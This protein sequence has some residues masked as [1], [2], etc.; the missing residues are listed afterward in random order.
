MR[1]REN[2]TPERELSRTL[3]ASLM[4]VAVVLILTLVSVPSAWAASK[5]KTLYKFT[6]GADGGRSSA[7]LI[8]DQ[9]GN[10]YGT[11]YQG[12][13]SGFGTVFKLAPSGHGGWKQ[14]VLH[15]FGEPQ[16]GIHPYA[17]LIFDI[18]GNLYGTTEDGGD[19]G[20]GTVFKLTPNGDGSWTESV[21]YSFNHN[22]DGKDGFGPLAGLVL[23][24]AGSLYGTTYWGGGT[25]G[26][27]VVFELTPNGDGS[28]TESVLHTFTN[29]RK[30]AHQ[31][32]LYPY[33]GLVFDL[34]GNLYGATERGGSYG[35]GTVFRLVANGDGSWTESLIHSF[36]GY[37]GVGPEGSLIFDQQGN[38]YGTVGGGGNHERGAVFELIPNDDGSWIESILHSFTFNDGYEPFAGLTFDQSGNLYGTTDGGGAYGWGTVFQLKPVKGGWKERVLH[39]F[40]NNPGAFPDSGVIFDAQGNLYGANTGSGTTFGS[41]FEIT[42]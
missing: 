26:Y 2:L 14:S 1:R 23:D 38:L 30:E 42:P 7:A 37:D 40:I 10:L 18:A 35:Y 3:G 8:F 21:L 15:S 13:A 36:N 5:F 41:V 28:W 4:A 39:S 20:Y 24:A 34:A 31:D 16:D 19:Y 9:M 29:D 25:N 11:T 22:Y 17:P 27:G 32:G 33:A 6:G 12:G